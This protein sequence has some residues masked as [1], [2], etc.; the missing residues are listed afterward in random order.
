[1]S[2]EV[3]VDED[4]LAEV[5]Q[6]K[7]QLFDHWIKCEAKKSLSSS[8]DIVWRLDGLPE[9]LKIQSNM[10]AA[11][12][13]AFHGA[14]A[15]GWS[16]AIGDILSL[17]ASGELTIE[18]PRLDAVGDHFELLNNAFGTS[19][20]DPEDEDAIEVL[21]DFLSH[22]LTSDIW[23]T[24]CRKLSDLDEGFCAPLFCVSDGTELRAKIQSA[25]A[26]QIDE[27]M[28]AFNN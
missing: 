28:S 26:D 9:E 2:V 10:L 27:L 4:L 17:P 7:C 22:Q 19:T 5:V 20:P 15:E 13:L 18:E 24:Y 23:Y 12:C 11:L 3:R 16:L 21:S 1:M 6:L 8:C 14:Q 25:I